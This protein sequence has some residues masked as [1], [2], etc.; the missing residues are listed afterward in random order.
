MQESEARERAGA[1]LMAELQQG[2]AE[3]AGALTASGVAEVLLSFSERV[4]GAAAGAVYVTRDDESTLHLLGARNLPEQAQASVLSLDAPLPLSAAARTRSALWF[5]SY[6]ALLR[7]YPQLVNAATPRER[8]Q[9]VVALPLIHGG[10]L[11][12]GFALSFAHA[13]EF[14]VSDKSWLESFASQCAL[15]VERAR[16]Y[17]AERE[18]RREA[19]SLF[20]ISESLKAARLDLDALVQRTT[21]EGTQ[22]VGADFGAFFYNLVNEAGETYVLYAL[23]G[24]PKEAFAKFGLPRNTPIFAP[25]FAGEGVVR[26]GDVRKDPRYGT[27]APHYGMPRGHLPVVS[28]L[29]VPVVSRSGSV[30]G[31]LFFGH[32]EADR[33]TE[34]HER[35]VSVIA[36]SAAAAID[37][38][39]LFEASRIAERNQRQ[40]VDELTETVRL[41]DLLAG[42]LAHDLRNPLGSILA[43]AALVLRQCEQGDSTRVAGPLNRIV[44]SGERMSRLI[45]QLLD[46]TR[47]RVG[48]GFELMVQEFDLVDVVRRVA[49]ELEEARAGTR[50]EFETVGD[51]RGTWDEDRLAQAFSNLLGNALRH[52]A[53]D[54]CVHVRL[55]GSDPERVSASIHNAGAIPSSAMGTLFVP[56][57]PRDASREQR[58]GLGLGLFITREIARAHGGTVEVESDDRTGTRF[59][60]ELPRSSAAAEPSAPTGKQSEEGTAPLRPWHTTEDLVDTGQKFRL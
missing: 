27:M 9:A 24:A 8:I 19:E 18:A 3:L 11:V 40:L 13:R 55:D 12:G 37:N 25:T 59:T 5:E 23:S 60:L 54:A 46:F 34:Q 6:G 53:R 56:L 29:A 7:E 47:I 4:L 35:M 31:G 14:A 28:Y 36:A 51:T 45:N 49:E 58:D 26:L 57:A 15:A 30:L 32:R 39:K 16:L 22:L 17:E 50:L 52:G 42:V 43:S 38:A 20:R 2:T 48:R 21:D 41:N 1:R 33:F 44:R 10:R